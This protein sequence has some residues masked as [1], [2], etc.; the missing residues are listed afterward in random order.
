MGE[1]GEVYG[2]RKRP[3]L[4]SVVP[5]DV[6]T[7]TVPVVAPAGTVVVISEPETTLKAAAVPLKL[8]LVAPVRSVPRIVTAAP[9]LP[10]VGSVST[11]GPRPTDRL[12]TVPAR[13]APPPVVVPYRSPL[14]SWTSAQMGLSPS[15]P[16]KACSV[17]SVPPGVILKTVPSLLAPSS[18]VVP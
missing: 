10:E 3:L 14:V 8:T 1:K 7:S 9:A 18:G 11:N 17:V 6:T 4:E 15:V 13:F 16:A 12:K 2:T 5:V